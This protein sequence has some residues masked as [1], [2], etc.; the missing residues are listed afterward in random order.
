MKEYDIRNMKE[1]IVF[2]ELYRNYISELGQ[3]SKRILKKPATK[4]EI[5][6]INTNPLLEKY[7]ITDETGKLIGFCLIGFDQN[8]QPGTDWF[9]AEFYISPMFRRQ[10]Y[11]T[12]SITEFLKTHPGNYC[13]FVLKENQQA[14]E[15]W[16][17][18]RTELKCTDIK[19]DY[20]ARK[21]TP[22]DCTFE[23]FL[24]ENN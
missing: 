4:E 22:K 14:Y 23:A 15:F 11:G 20:D 16:N 10:G 1:R 13:Y 6:D 19:S 3:Y 24:Y 18:V 2:E 12:A 5:N 17:K 7:F 21:H 8:T 9:I